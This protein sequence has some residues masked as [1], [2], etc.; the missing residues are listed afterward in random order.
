M[1]S[2]RENMPALERLGESL[3]ASIAAAE[4]RRAR[5]LRSVLIGAPVLL[6]ALA[7]AGF[8]V[9]GT[10]PLTTQE[11]VAAVVRANEQFE[12]LPSAPVSYAKSETTHPFGAP[13]D[14]SIVALMSQTVEIWQR[15]DGEVRM[16]VSDSEIVAPTGSTVPEIQ[17]PN[18]GLPAISEFDQSSL[19]HVP[20]A[21]EIEKLESLR[22]N[23]AELRTELG[24]A[25]PNRLVH[26]LQYAAPRLSVELR[27]ALINELRS[28]GTVRII[29]DDRIS[30]TMLANGIRCVAEFAMKSGLLVASKS[31]IV[32]RSGAR[33]HPGWPIGSIIESYE[34]KS[35]R[36]VVELPD[37]TDRA[38]SQGHALRA[39]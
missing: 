12:P 9:F 18:D 37:P 39:P 26:M 19:P 28:A 2:P 32:A 30:I 22:D 34:L 35:F 1:E 21:A 11:A 20:T 38:G 15:V 3:F 36:W 27:V 6:I 25:G 23:P 5:R 7:I 33:H 4:K 31:V 29:S 13:N 14:A 8:A 10:H 24:V 17:I 16:R